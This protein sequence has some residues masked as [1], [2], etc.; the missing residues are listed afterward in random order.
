MGA[1]VRFLFDTDFSAKPPE[2]TMPEED[3]V[4][5]VELEVHLEEVKKAEAAAYERGLQDGQRSAEAIAQDHLAREAQRLA[6]AADRM[7]GLIDADMKR[8]EGEAAALSAAIAKKISGFALQRFP[9]DQVLG[10]I[11]ECLAPLRS[12]RHLAVRV[13][14]ADAEK[15][16]E[17]IER[18]AAKN[19]FEGRLLILGEPETQPGDCKIEWADGGILFEQ[20]AVLQALDVAMNDYWGADGMPEAVGETADDAEPDEA[21]TSE[22]G[23]RGLEELNNE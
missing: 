12:V 19:G 7:I 20:E 11:S 4:P 16:K 15:L 17:P 21:Q 3:E 22:T 1:P 9:E 13:N 14:D 6:D 8:I 2:E 23:P 18:L 10:L 5:H